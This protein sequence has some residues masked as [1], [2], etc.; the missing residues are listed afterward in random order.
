[1]SVRSYNASVR[2]GNWSENICLEE[3]G[4]KNY[5]EKRER[6]E[7]LIQKRSKLSETI[8]KRTELSVTKDGLLHFG[9]HVMVM[10]EAPTEQVA[11]SFG[12]TPRKSCTLAVN[13]AESKMH[14][15]LRFEGSC[16][17]SASK[18][19]ESCARNSFVITPVKDTNIPSGSPLL[20]GQHFYLRTLPGIGGDLVLRSDMATFQASAKKS[21]KQL[22]EFVEEPSYATEWTIL[23]YNPQLRMETEG[24]PVPA[25]QK[26]IFNHCKTNQDLCILT[27]NIVRTPFGIDY[28]TVAYTSLDTHRAEKDFNHWI[29]VT[30]SPSEPRTP[31]QILKVGERQ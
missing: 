11:N 26:I 19:L 25:N 28:E 2:V 16:G 15:A 31:A 6:G 8:L 20:Y 17:A 3:D 24:L 23:C 9:D 21:R 18:N 22:I 29:M 1:M 5:L 4:L 14:E 27:D 30:G 13:M 12:D 7:L 10:N